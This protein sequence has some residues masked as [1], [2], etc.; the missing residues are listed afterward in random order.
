MINPITTLMS[1]ST[2]NEA[3]KTCALLLN[4]IE[5]E[6]RAGRLTEQQYVELMVGVED[7]R[8]II[9]TMNEIEANQLIHEAVVQLVELAK[10]IKP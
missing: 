3:I 5:T 10:S 7:L 9:Q 1:L 2:D 4:D 6:L 8:G